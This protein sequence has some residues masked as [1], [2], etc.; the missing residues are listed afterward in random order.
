MTRTAYQHIAF[1]SVC[2]SS[3]SIGS[4]TSSFSISV[5]ES[6]TESSLFLCLQLKKLQNLD[7]QSIMENDDSARIWYDY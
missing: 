5:K 3:I 1:T 4:G 7:H 6:F 2:M